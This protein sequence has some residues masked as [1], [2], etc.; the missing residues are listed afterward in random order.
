VRCG[1]FDTLHWPQHREKVRFV[2][3][4]G[5]LKNKLCRTVPE[6]CG[7]A[8]GLLRSRGPGNRQQATLAHPG[9][10]LVL[11][12]LAKACPQGGDLSESR[13]VLRDFGNM[14]SPSVLFALERWLAD[15]KDPT[16]WLASY[17][18]GFSCHACAVERL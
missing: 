8:V 3:Q 7:E 15:G 10:K 16:A 2:N 9:G 4:G 11:D 12:A 6:V 18:A 17:G 14:S 5:K 1:G 13:S